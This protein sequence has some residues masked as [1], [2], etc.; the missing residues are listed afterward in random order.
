MWV[1]LIGGQG[2]IVASND[3]AARPHARHIDRLREP[4]GLKDILALYHGHVEE[5]ESSV[6]IDPQGVDLFLGSLGVPAQTWIATD[7]NLMLEYGTPKGNALDGP[8]SMKHNIATLQR[9]Q[10]QALAQVR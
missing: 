2:I 7:D 4:P 1:Y 5:L 9:F 10:S 3:P 6:I 8:A